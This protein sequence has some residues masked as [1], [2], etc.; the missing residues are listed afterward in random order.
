MSVYS[1]EALEHMR[2]CTSQYASVVNQLAGEVITLES[3]LDELGRG[4]MELASELCECQS[5]N[6]E[7]Q[8]QIR[9]KN[10]KLRCTTDWLQENQPDVFRRGYWEA[11]LK[12][13]KS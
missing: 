10:A 7:L 12:A 1:I 5:T 13:E 3:K 8:E 6:K 11:I 2:D 4:Q 9:I